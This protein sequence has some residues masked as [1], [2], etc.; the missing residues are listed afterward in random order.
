MPRGTVGLHRFSVISNEEVAQGV[1]RFEISSDVARELA[2]GQF[3]NFEVPGDATHILRIPL[4][5]SETDRATACTVIYYA[6]MGEGTRR[7]AR[8]LPGDASTVVGPCGTGWRLPAAGSER[9]LLVAGGIGLPPVAAAG[10]MLAAAGIPFDLIA[11][12]QTEAKVVFRLLSEIEPLMADDAR[13]LVTT[14]DGS[15]GIAGFATQAMDRLLSERGYGCIYTC[16]P[17]AMMGGVAHRSARA[18]IACQASLERMMGCAFGACGVCN[19]ALSA[20]GYASCCMDGPV[21]D[22]EEVAW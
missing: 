16:G 18:G 14:D 2:P 20:G 3:M 21:F 1:Y 22:A 12:A 19:V 17:Q 13:V 4:S 6:A 7:L 15:Y 9:C 11:G 10:R 8:M 5:F